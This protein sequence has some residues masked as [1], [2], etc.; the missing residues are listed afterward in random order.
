MP[1][2]IRVARRGVLEILG[3]EEPGSPNPR[4]NTSKEFFEPPPSGDKAE[5]CIRFVSTLSPL[6]IVLTR[7]VDT[8]WRQGGDMSPLL[9]GLSVINCE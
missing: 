1:R 2:L 3:L 7:E 8:K 4:R 5:T 6:F 9:D